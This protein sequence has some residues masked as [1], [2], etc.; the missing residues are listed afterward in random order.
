[1]ERTKFSNLNQTLKICPRKVLVKHWNY[2]E[3]TGDIKILLEVEGSLLKPPTYIYNNNKTLLEVLD[4]KKNVR[5]SKKERN[6]RYIL[7]AKRLYVAVSSKKNIKY[8]PN[9]LLEWCNDI[10]R[11]EEENG[12]EYN[13][14][15]KLL[16]WY[17]DHIGDDYVPVVESGYSLR[18]KFLRL[19]DAMNRKPLGNGYKKPFVIEDGMKYSLCS[20]GRYRNKSGALYIE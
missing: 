2:N 6:I 1:M 8:N 10:R 20:D 16:D 14:L 9:Q 15:E 11:L 3:K 18:L 17:V 4:T 12:I 13:R 7:L 19:E 5:H